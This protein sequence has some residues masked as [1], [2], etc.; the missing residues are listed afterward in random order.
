MFNTQIQYLNNQEKLLFSLFVTVF[1]FLFFLIFQPFGVN[2]YDPSEKISETFLLG[3]IIFCCS[4]L[5]AQIIFEFIIQ[6][7]LLSYFSTINI[8]ICYLANSLWLGL[9]LYLTY[10]ILGNWH[11]FGILS[12]L[13][14]TKNLS[15]LFL[16]PYTS[17]VV[18]ARIRDLN[19]TLNSYFEYES[20]IGE[21]EKVLIFKSD[22]ASETFSL[23]LKLLLY[24]ASDDNYISLYYLGNEGIDRHLIRKSLK[25][26]VEDQ[27]HSSLVRCHR[28]YMINLYNLQ[29]MKG[30]RNKMEIF[31]KG[32]DKGI[33]V[34]RHYVDVLNNIIHEK[35]L[36][37][38]PNN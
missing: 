22:N 18:Y 25:S 26:L 29:Q 27:L 8:I 16:I 9:I 23:K 19:E 2:N 20:E 21:G 6:K 3:I 13:D 7:I 12:F 1:F 31:L 15:M 28:S 34:S 17:M 35:A 4:A 5:F 38:T 30:N 32:L 14:F 24:I 11:D 36:Q 33:P 37:F 10:N